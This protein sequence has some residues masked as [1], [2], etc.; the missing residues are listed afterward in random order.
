MVCASGVIAERLRAP[1]A[2]ENASRGIETIS[3]AAG[4]AGQAQVLRRE[5][6]DESCGGRKIAGDENRAVSCERSPR[7][8]RFRKLRE[9]LFNFSSDI[10]AEAQRGGGE[11]RDGIRIVFRLCDQISRDESWIAARCKDN[12]FCRPGEQVNRAI[13]ANQ[14]LGS[15]DIA[16]AGPK[17]F[18]HRR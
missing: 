16:I 2:Q 17:Y 1:I 7:G 6:I 12:S 3:E 8:I 10:S 4:D 5:S 18:V 11:K 14:P 9:L 13:R 15:G